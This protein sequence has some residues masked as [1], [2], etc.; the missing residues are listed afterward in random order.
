MT[1]DLLDATTQ[2]V[3]ESQSGKDV[4]L[5]FKIDAVGS[6]YVLKIHGAYTRYVLE[7]R[8]KRLDRPWEETLP[9]DPFWWEDPL[10]PDI[11]TILR[12]VED[13]IGFTALPRGI[14]SVSLLAEG[15]GMKLYDSNVQVLQ[16]GAPN[17]EESVAGA[18]DTNVKVGE[19]L[20]TSG[21]TAGATYLL[22]IYRITEAQSTE[23]TGVVPVGANIP[24]TLQSG[25]AR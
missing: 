21:L 14:D 4:S 6:K 18:K 24:Y 22:Q 25:F 10:G 12:E 5:M 17:Y 3:L 1:V 7:K 13:W 8:G 19:H 16:E 23:L 9:Y 11:R 15:L 20:D 2:A